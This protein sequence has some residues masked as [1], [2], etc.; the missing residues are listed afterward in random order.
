[1]R[2]EVLHHLPNEE[3]VCDHLRE[4]SFGPFGTDFWYR[5][6]VFLLLSIGLHQRAQPT[7]HFSFALFFPAR[8]AASAPAAAAAALPVSCHTALGH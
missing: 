1:L 7:P 5:N 8:C 6:R 2:F 4:L 3:V